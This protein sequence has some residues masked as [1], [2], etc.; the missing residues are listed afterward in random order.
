M[1]EPGFMYIEMGEGLMIEGR[2]YSTYFFLK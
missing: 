2:E 1:H